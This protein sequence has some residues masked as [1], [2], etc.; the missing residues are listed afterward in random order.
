MILRAICER[1]RR[2]TRKNRYLPLFSRPLKL[3]FQSSTISRRVFRAY[4]IHLADGLWDSLLSS[5]PESVQ[6]SISR[7]WFFSFSDSSRHTHLLRI[8]GP[9]SDQFLNLREMCNG[10]WNVPVYVRYVLLEIGWRNRRVC[11]TSSDCFLVSPLQGI[12]EGITCSMQF[13]QVSSF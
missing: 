6:S 13:I 8:N 9:P 1:N 5:T 10:F 4:R 2:W 12:A 3:L 11:T 7:F